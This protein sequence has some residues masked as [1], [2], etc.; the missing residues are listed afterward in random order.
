MNMDGVAVERSVWQISAA[1]KK[2]RRYRSDRPHASNAARIIASPS[3]AGI[4]G[5]RSTAN[6]YGRWGRSTSLQPTMDN[7]QCT[8]SRDSCDLQLNAQPQKC[9]RLSEMNRTF[10]LK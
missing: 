1:I 6:W 8:W 7:A 3:A 2:N 5:N 4:L 10:Q 9:G